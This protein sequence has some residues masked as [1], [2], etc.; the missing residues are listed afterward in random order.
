MRHGTRPRM[1][2]QILKEEEIN[3]TEEKSNSLTSVA[4]VDQ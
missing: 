4:N 3:S 1:I 2:N